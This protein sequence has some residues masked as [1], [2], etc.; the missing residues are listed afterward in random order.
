MEI[1]DYQKEATR[2]LN[3]TF[4]KEKQT[5]NMIAG[6]FGEA[7]EVAD[8]IKKHLYQ[9]HDLNKEH[10]IEELGDTMFY[11][12]NLCTI[13]DIDLKDVLKNNNQKLWKRY[14]DGFDKTRSKNRE[15]NTDLF[16]W[17]SKL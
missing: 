8:I 13:Y 6:L 12:T 10:L 17:K 2:T 14:P 15:D 9:G 3:K 1:K 4:D 16:G 7:G 5:A 11:V